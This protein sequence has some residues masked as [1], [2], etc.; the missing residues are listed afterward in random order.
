MTRFSR[1]SYSLALLVAFFMV[2]FA[3]IVAQVVLTREFLVVL[4]G[5]ELCIGVIL[6]SWLLGIGLG[7]WLGAL[8]ADRFGYARGIFMAGLAALALALPLQIAAVRGARGLLGVGA[9]E[10]ISLLA[11]L[12][13]CPL[14]T[15]PSS[16]LVGFLFPFAGRLSAEA[17]GEAVAGVAELYIAESAGSLAGG[18]IFTFLLVELL[19]PLQAALL[20]AALMA[21]GGFAVALSVE[22]PVL[23]RAAAG[24][25]LAAVVFAG[26]ALPNV[27]VDW[28]RRLALMRWRQ[29]A[30]EIEPVATADSRFQHLDVG[31]IGEQ[32]SVYFN[33]SVAGYA[34]ADF[35]HAQLTHFLLAQHPNPRTVLLI[36]D[37]TE[38]MLPALLEHPL[39]RLDYVLLDDE[40]L[41]LTAPLKSDEQLE[42]LR[43]S[44]LH[45]HFGDG[46]GFLRST[47]RRFD[48]IVTLV[49]PPSTAMLNR[50]YTVE[51]FREA[52]SHLTAG[53][54]FI[55]SL[56]MTP[57]HIGGIVGAYVGSIA[58]ALSET[59]PEIIYSYDP[60]DFAL[61]A[62]RPGAVTAD[63]VEL[64]RRWRSR[65][66]STPYFHE[67]LFRAW[68]L[69]ERI[70]SRKAEIESLPPAGRNT[71]LQPTAYLY[72]LLIWNRTAGGDH[73][74]ADAINGAILALRRA[75]IWPAAA[76][77]GVLLAA[78][79]ILRQK[80]ER[81]AERCISLAV[82]ATTGFCAMAL[83]I[84]V[85][86][87]YQNL[88]GYVYHEIGLIV[89]V[90]MAGLAAG[91][92]TGRRIMSRPGRSPRRPL[93]AMEA[94]MIAVCLLV[95]AAAGLGGTLIAGAPGG[96][97]VPIGLLA[98][99][100]YLTGAEFPLAVAF[101]M[102]RR[103]EAVGAGA[104]AV[105]SADHLG[106]ALGA[107]LTGVLLVPIFGIWSA[108]LLLVCLKAASG[109]LVLRN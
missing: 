105:D 20:N 92:W 49:P 3:A 7:A 100:G 78:A 60:R 28:D 59:F 64:E 54:V 46:R 73:A 1:K 99:A 90:F 74:I 85:I 87:A 108:A 97:F 77:V 23:R 63:H 101:Y 42:A 26:L 89:A 76:L 53:G 86:F 81:P 84:L 36:G 22:R 50:Y 106:A 83:E 19:L 93:L 40:V 31:R 98:L 13:F 30:G 4:Y 88:F 39:E 66:I 45:V 57:G 24:L 75:S 17:R 65:G 44:R 70:A 33:G 80:R 67:Y 9:G 61:C 94:G 52:R 96:R 25:F 62:S 12:T 37:G 71:D 47:A 109:A 107:A 91:A 32:F 2:G 68:M 15:A 10:M 72:R 56:P 35:S 95:P 38:G 104:G 21:V 51:F 14:V 58:E 69:P 79:L 5:N 102:R 34:P 55:I 82:V 18:L 6:A 48:A 103:A 16:L 8:T 27:A 43:D 11:M 41:R 29:N